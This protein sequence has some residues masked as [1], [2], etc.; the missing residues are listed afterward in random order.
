MDHEV[1]IQST[2]GPSGRESEGSD[3]ADLRSARCGDSARSSI[4]GPHPHA[5]IGTGRSIASEAGAVSERPVI[6][7]IAGRVSGVEKA[8]LGTTFVGTGI[9]L[10]DRGRG[11]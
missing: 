4:A 7:K 1:S 9:L 8:I 2:E 6:A 11:G 5:A 10:R 3:P